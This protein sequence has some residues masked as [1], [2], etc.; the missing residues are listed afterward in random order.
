MEKIPSN[1]KN[2]LVYECKKFTFARSFLAPGEQDW[3][4]RQELMVINRDEGKRLVGDFFETWIFRFVRLSRDLK[5][6]CGVV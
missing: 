6:F 5:I 3:Q 2:L 4:G 1:S